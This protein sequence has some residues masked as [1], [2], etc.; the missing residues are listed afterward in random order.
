MSGG[1]T[2]PPELA[3]RYTHIKMAMHDIDNYVEK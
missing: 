3:G 1:G 2:M